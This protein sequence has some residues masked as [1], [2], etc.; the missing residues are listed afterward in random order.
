V[1]LLTALTISA[2]FGQTDQPG[3]KDYPGISRMPNIS[4]YRYLQFD[5]FSFTVSENGKERKQPVEGQVYSFRYVTNPG[6]TPV[7]ALQIVRNFQNAV[8]GAGGAGSAR[9]RQWG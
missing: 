9:L 1:G 3:S 4:S 7:S 2:V 8:R 6:A 5:S